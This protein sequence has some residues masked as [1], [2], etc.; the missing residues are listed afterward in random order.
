VSSQAPRVGRPN[1][2]SY[3]LEGWPTLAGRF[4]IKQ[5]KASSLFP[6]RPSA[7]QLSRPRTSSSLPVPTYTLPFIT[8]GTE[9]VIPGPSTSL[10]P[11]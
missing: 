11:A 6:L 3:P 9:K 8:V 2:E 1:W 4:Q 7:G 5:K 10:C